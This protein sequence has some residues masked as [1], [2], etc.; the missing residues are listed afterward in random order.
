NRCCFYINA[1]EYKKAIKDLYKSIE[2]NSF[3]LEYMIK[4]KE[5]NKLR[6]FDEYKDLIE[7][8]F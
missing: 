4:D 5:I 7:S 1:G 2:L 3:F 6:K 8:K